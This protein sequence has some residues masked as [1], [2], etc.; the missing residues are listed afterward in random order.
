LIE[1]YAIVTISPPHASAIITILLQ[2]RVADF[3]LFFFF[4]AAAARCRRSPDDSC[5]HFSPPCR[6]A[7]ICL[8]RASA[9]ATLPLAMMMFRFCLFYAI[10]HADVADIIS[11]PCCLLRFRALRALLHTRCHA[12]LR[13]LCRLC[14]FIAIRFVITL[15][16]CRCCPLMMPPL[17]AAAATL[18]DYAAAA[19]PCHA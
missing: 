1:P 15:R 12:V 7:A 14:L 19:A 6:A 5:R 11:P 2:G 3:L 16:D 8:P 4:Y 17:R 18:Y 10:R 13:L 9:Y